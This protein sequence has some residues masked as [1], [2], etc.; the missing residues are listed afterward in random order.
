[1]TT[2]EQ[3]LAHAKRNYDEKILT[4]EATEELIVRIRPALPKGWEACHRYYG[5]MLITKSGE[6][7]TPAQEFKL[8][9]KIVESA[10]GGKGTDLEKN[11]QVT[12]GEITALTATCFSKGEVWVGIEIQLISPDHIENCEITYK[13]KWTKVAI[14]SDKC[15]G[16]GT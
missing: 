6:G 2:K 1:M 7:K 16:L 5:D 12:D 13:R 8:V 4:I 14:V 11:A 3:V 10:I 9:C 15:L